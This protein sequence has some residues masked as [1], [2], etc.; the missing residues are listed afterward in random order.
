VDFLVELE[1]DFKNIVVENLSRKTRTGI[2][3]LYKDTPPVIKK[4]LKKEVVGTVLGKYGTY[5]I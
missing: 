2:E 1:R 3:N 4:Y 5:L